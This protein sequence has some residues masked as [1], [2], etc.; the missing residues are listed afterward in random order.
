VTVASEAAVPERLFPQFSLAERDR[1]W[2]LLRA[3]MKQQGLDAIVAPPNTGHVTDNQA[4]ARYISQCGGGA[5]ADVGVVFPLAGEVTVVAT[6]A[7]GR[8]GSP[9]VQRWVTDLRESHRRF[10][11]PFAERLRELGLERGRIG[12]TGLGFGTR[13]PE[14]TILL[15]TYRDMSD[16]LP[17]ATFV[18]ASDLLQD[19]R[20]PKSAE[21]IAVLQR[22]LDL[23]ERGH[24][25]KALWAQPGVPEYVVWAETLHAMFVRGSEFSVHFNW[26]SGRHPMGSRPRAAM[27]RLEVGDVLQSEIESSVL[28]YRAQQY[29]PVA[30]NQAS[31]VLRELSKVHAEL[32]PRVLE[33]LRA[34]ITVR[35]FVEA[36]VRIG[37]TIAPSRGP[38]AGCRANMTFHG[39]GLGDD[40]PLVLTRA[41][42]GLTSI[43]ESTD[44]TWDH[45]FP[46]D[47]VYICKPT[48]QAADGTASFRWGD[49]V[50]TT[51]SGAVRMG[52]APH[53]LVISAP[54]AVHW[55]DDLPLETLRPGE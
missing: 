20:E 35:E 39:R 28:G 37:E 40:R 11:G 27:R 18:D 14:G 51:E 4:D 50:R 21:E 22:S 8:W 44:R 30:V 19:A 1:R 3:L 43:Y 7:T 46:A 6:V 48:L 13:T 34:G 31:E 36:T 15:G 25:A 23:V 5:L 17:N 54:R 9:A 33:A 42:A 10:G 32:Y 12:V 29:R 2:A 24:E 55:P 47:G 49:T 41:G 38:A 52:K 53:G 26:Y 16:A 45:V